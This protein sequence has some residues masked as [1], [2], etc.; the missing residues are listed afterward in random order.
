MASSL[1][2]DQKASP[3][4][5]LPDEVAKGIQPRFSELGMSVP[6]VQAVYSKSFRRSSTL[7][8]PKGTA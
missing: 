8:C 3:G 4:E 5:R 1:W 7:E 2:L 6:E